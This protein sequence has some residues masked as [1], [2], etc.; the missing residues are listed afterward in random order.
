MQ[1]T[2]TEIQNF[3]EL[4][5]KLKDK[6]LKLATA[7]KMAKLFKEMELSI[8][9]YS[10]KL[11]EI[12]NTYALKDDDGNFVVTEDGEGV[13]IKEDQLGECQAA[14][15]ELHTLPI[16]IGGAKFALDEF[17]GLELTTADALLMLP[18]LGGEE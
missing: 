16:E 1:L 8:S 14:M 7:Y 15:E 18:F 6:P 11:Q 10:E 13:T 12:V 17:E 3:K 5:M 9:F 2:I 4:Y